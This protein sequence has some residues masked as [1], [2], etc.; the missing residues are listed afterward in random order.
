M[1][2]ELLF[3]GAIDA[4]RSKWVSKPVRISCIIFVSLVFLIAVA[5][6]LLA[7]VVED[8]SLVKRGVYLILGIGAAIYY[9]SLWRR[10]GEAA[11]GWKGTAETE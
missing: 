3:Q 2:L 6:L 9:C 10:R 8:Q 4:A 11:N 7:C 1:W 5:G